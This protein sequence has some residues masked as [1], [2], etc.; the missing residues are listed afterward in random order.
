MWWKQWDIAYLENWRVQLRMMLSGM[1][2]FSGVAGWLAWKSDPGGAVILPIV[3]AVHFAIN[4][5]RVLRYG[6]AHRHDGEHATQNVA[7]GKPSAD[8]PSATQK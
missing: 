4:S 6:R 3:M 5:V 8:A 7:I 2:V 1:V